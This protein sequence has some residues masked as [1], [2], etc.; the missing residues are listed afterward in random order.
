MS[1]GFTPAGSRAL[2]TGAAG[3]IGSALCRRLRQSGAEVHGVSRRYRD[4]AGVRWWAADLADLGATRRILQQVNPD[5]VFHLASH[6][7]GNRSLDTVLPTVHDNL[8]TTVNLL[9]AAAERGGPRVVLAGSMEECEPDESDPV[10]GSPYAAAKMAASTYVRMFHALYSLSVVNLRVFM[11]YGPGQWDRTKLV[12]YVINALL[13]G[14]QPKLSSGKRGV[15]WIYVDDVV[16]AFVVAA[17]AEKAEGQTMDV[18]S[19]K[20]VTIRELVEDLAALIGGS[21]EPL[22]GALPD[23]PL[24]HNRV[25][26]VIRTHD[27]IGWQPSTPL[28]EGLTSTVQWFRER[29]QT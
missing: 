5:V 20:L 2:V 23:R 27:V 3:F 19:G 26:N 16:D 25:A 17:Q 4:G 10:P 7:S 14:D 24:E 12:P 21:E 6:V 15:D 22:F 8:L 18:G 28:R 9:V 29:Q 1:M 13:L 11:V